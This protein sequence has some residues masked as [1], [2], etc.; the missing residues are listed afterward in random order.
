MRMRWWIGVRRQWLEWDDAASLP[1][2]R[3]EHGRM[4]EQGPPSWGSNWLTLLTRRLSKVTWP[5]AIWKNKNFASQP[6]QIGDPKGPYLHL[7]LA[8]HEGFA[9][10]WALP[11]YTS[12]VF[13]IAQ[14]NKLANFSWSCKISMRH[15][16]VDWRRWR[17]M[18]TQFRKGRNL[19]E[20]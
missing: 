2:D 10:Q 18:D 14:R 3:F 19:D 4:Q 1:P 9:N 11:R 16:L 12:M 7:S 6:C 15:L 5:I 17:P 8:L 13:I 20:G